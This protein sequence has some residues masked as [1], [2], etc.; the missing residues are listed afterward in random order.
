[1]ASDI[2]KLGLD[3]N[4]VFSVYQPARIV[5]FQLRTE[6]EENSILIIAKAVVS[7]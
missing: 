1:M 5:L 4:N 3:V 2:S 6:N 7:A